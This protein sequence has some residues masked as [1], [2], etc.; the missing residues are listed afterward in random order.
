MDSGGHA[1]TAATVERD[2]TSRIPSTRRAEVFGL[3]QP[4][5]ERWADTAAALRSALPELSRAEL[6]LLC[7][8]V[9]AGFAVRGCMPRETWLL[10]SR[11]AFDHVTN[12]MP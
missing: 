9:G 11:L 2:G 3:L 5:W 6:A 7:V 8:Y 4:I 1:V 12:V 10:I